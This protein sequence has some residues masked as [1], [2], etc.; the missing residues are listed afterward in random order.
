MH[1]DKKSFL[2]SSEELNVKMAVQGRNPP[3]DVVKQED[4]II[5]VRASY[6]QTLLVKRPMH[7]K[8]KLRG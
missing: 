3:L 4:F 2:Y 8:E 6:R 5:C 1:L 7:V